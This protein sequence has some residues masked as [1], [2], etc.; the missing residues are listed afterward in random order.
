[1]PTVVQTHTL[2]T[3]AFDTVDFETYLTEPRFYRFDDLTMSRLSFFLINGSQQTI[4][5]NQVSGI[6]PKVSGDPQDSCLGPILFIK[7]QIVHC[8]TQSC[9]DK[10]HQTL[11]YPSSELPGAVARMKNQFEA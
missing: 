5:N 3:K 9:S 4:V 11:S 8:S 6:L 10:S 1:M 2:W 7:Y